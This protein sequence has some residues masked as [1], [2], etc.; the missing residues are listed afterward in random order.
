YPHDRGGDLGV[1]TWPPQ[2]WQIGGGTVWGWV[3]YDRARDVV[4]Y[5]TAN[6]G[7]WNP[8]QRPGDNKWTCTLFA[9]R[10][11]DGHALWA[12]QLTPHDEHD[13][14]GVNEN[15]LVDLAIGGRTRPVLL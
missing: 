11:G 7:P 1:K 8:D 3:T 2:A 14:D 6:P 15:V 13:Y 9:R 10:L 12:Y 4:Y 5:G